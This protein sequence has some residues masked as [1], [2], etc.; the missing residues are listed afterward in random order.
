[1]AGRR[2]LIAGDFMEGFAIAGA[3]EFENWLANERSSVRRVSIDVLLRYA[4]V[5]GAAEQGMLPA[6]P[7]APLHWSL[8]A[9]RRCAW[10]CGAWCLWATGPALE[11]YELFRARLKREV[12]SSPDPATESLAERVRHERS[13]RATP[14]GKAGEDVAERRPPLVGREVE[15][16]R[17]LDAV[18]QA[19]RATALIIQGDSGTGKTRLA[20]ELL[21]RLRLDGIP[22]AGM[23]ASRSR[24]SRGVERGSGP[25]AWGS[26]GRFRCSGSPG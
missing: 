25:G 20:D 14:T 8:P 19:C 6:S 10:S 23:R 11:R 17:L 22:V 2:E 5:L 26:A 16:G 24:P 21:A 1:M 9:S 3:S 13:P 7:G 15:L 4:D 12:G 18:A